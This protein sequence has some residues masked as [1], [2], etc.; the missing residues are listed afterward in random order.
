MHNLSIDLSLPCVSH[1]TPWPLQL[2]SLLLAL[3]PCYLLLPFASSSKSLLN[4]IF[5]KDVTLKIWS[6]EVLN[7]FS[8]FYWFSWKL[9]VIYKFW[10]HHEKVHE[11][12]F[13]LMCFTERRCMQNSKLGI[14]KIFFPDFLK[15]LLISKF[16]KYP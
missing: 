8:S 10:K 15:L 1:F 6:T 4:Y 2:P 5:F 7:I 16:Q 13:W 3:L 9:L 14:F 12:V 11:I